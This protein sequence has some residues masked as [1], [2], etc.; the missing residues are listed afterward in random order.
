M[1]RKTYL[2]VVLVLLPCLA[3]A[4]ANSSYAPLSTYPVVTGNEEV[5]APILYPPY[6]MPYMDGVDLIGDTVTIGTTW[7]E[8]QH[9]GTI[10]RMV[11]LSDDGY[12]HFVW[13]NG[14]DNG[15]TSRH[16]F[17]NVIDP[18]GTQLWPYTGYAVESTQRGGYTV[19][20]VDFGGIGFPAF[21]SVTTSANAHTA[22]ASDFFPHAG[23][24]LTNEP[25][26]LYLGGVEQEVIWPRA[27]FDQRQ[28]LHVVS[29]ENPLSGVAGDPQRHY[30]TPGTYNPTTFIVEFPS[31]PDTWT[32]MTWTM[33]IA[34]DVATSPVSDRVLFA[35]C[36]SKDFYLQP[37][38]TSQWNNDIH[39]MID[40]DGLDLHFENYFNL[41][42]FHDPDPAWLPDTVMADMDT[43]RAYTDLSTYIDHNDWAHVVFTTPS[44]FD[45]E[46]TRYWHASIVWHWS[47][48]FPGEFQMV[49]N[50]FDDWWW[51]YTD[52]G[53]WNVKAQRPMLAEDPETG[54]L[55]CM[56]Q[57]Y[58]C[59]TL[60]L[61]AAGYPSGEIYV[62]MSADGGENWSE[63]VNITNTVSPTN[64]AP[65][66]CLSELTPSIAKVADD[67]IHM[68]YVLDRDAG[69]VV[70]DEGSW[71]YNEVK[72]HKVAV[73][74]FSPTPYV[75][76]DVPFHVEHGPPLDIPGENLRSQP[77][78]FSLGQNYPN[79][80]NPTTTISFGLDQISEVTLKVYNL[81]GEEV[82]TVAN[83]TYGTGLHNVTFDGSNLSSGVYIYKL[84]A[85][86]RTL[87]GKM[88][89]MK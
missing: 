28:T 83:G 63:G 74:E 56:Y 78:E 73:D 35:W 49:H 89:L 36:Y 60:A 32:E 10:G 65:G 67:F 4:A 12:L 43:L 2:M 38:D 7:Y 41:T 26:W 77:V 50:A 53:A 69:F 22:V 47:E 31:D 42:Q 37:A 39:V 81:Q 16:V 13:M 40:D 76:Q 18:G 48:E 61:S 23:A 62:S 9:N 70:Q 86:S 79:P 64:A 46:G 71:T 82:A 8:G 20:D 21:H 6:T 87:N 15:A 88:V 1:V 51:N 59:D 24:F 84:D 80:F 45:Y 72:Y 57:V 27:M 14:L 33:T 68:I 34:G 11:E 58:D 5:D 3:L 54:Y 25:D 75:T 19:L 55:Y 66:Q 29:C 85:G 44:Y 52:C 17:Y 30:Y